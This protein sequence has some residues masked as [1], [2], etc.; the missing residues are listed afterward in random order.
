KLLQTVQPANPLIQSV[1]EQLHNLRVNIQ[2]NLA[3]IKKSL[4]I[5]RNDL[6]SKTGG[7]QS[8]ISQIP[9]V[10]RNLLEIQ[11][12]QGIKQALYAYLLQKREES[13]I[14]LASAVANTRIIDPAITNNKPVSPKT[15]LVGLIAIAIGLGVP[16]GALYAKDLLDDKVGNMRD[17]EK[18]TDAPVL[19]ELVHHDEEEALVV[20]KGSRTAIAELFRLIRTNLQFA[21]PGKE[22]KVLMVTSSMSGEGKTFFSI[23]VGASLALSGKKVV[24]LEF[25]IRKPKLMKDIGLSSQKGRGFTSFLVYEDIVLAD[26]VQPTNLVDNLWVIPS[27]P[28]PPNPAELLLSPKIEKLFSELRE[29]FDII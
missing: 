11:R 16:I 23:N 22:A 24:L 20:K 17:V 21:A 19:G 3:N 10:E 12:Q 25:D 4:V 29:H 27:G 18:A 9:A 14:S 7:F 28:I 13:A 8:R 6:Q 5:T 26:I 15:L 2:E 1:D